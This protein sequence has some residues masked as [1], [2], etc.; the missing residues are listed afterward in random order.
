MRKTLWKRAGAVLLCV[1]LALPS[2]V[3]YAAEPIV[4]V[5][6]DTTEGLQ[7]ADLLI[8]SAR[9]LNEFAQKVTNGNNYAGQVIKLTNDIA[10]DG[11]T[12]NNFTPIGGESIRQEFAGTFDGCG[13]TISGIDVTNADN[14]GL[15]YA[16][17]TSGIVKNVTVK[18]SYFSGTNAGAIA[19]RNTGMILNCRNVNSEITGKGNIGGIV[20]SNNGTNGKVQ[21][22]T[23]SGNV[24]LDEKALNGS[25]LFG[26]IGGVVGRNT[27]NIYN[28]CNTGVLTVPVYRTIVGSAGVGGV[29]GYCFVDG[30]I[31][32]CYN[33]G[34][35]QGGGS[36]NAGI[37][38]NTYG[39]VAN[40]YSSEESAPV[41]FAVMNGTERNC[42]A[43]PEATMKTATF[44]NQLNSNR[45]VN[46][47]W[48]EWEFRAEAGTPVLVEVVD[49]AKCGITLGGLSFEYNGIEKKPSVK[50]TNGVKAMY[51]NKD[52]TVTYENNV[53]AG[54][55]T[56][57]IEGMGRYASGVEKTFTIT[58][59]N[60][61]KCVIMLGA[62]SYA[63][64]GQ[65]KMPV[66]S[67]KYGS[68]ILVAGTDYTVSYENNKNVGTAKVVVTGKGNYT[69]N[70]SK[71][72]IITKGTQ[73]LNYTKTFTKAYGAKAFSLKV[74][75]I[76]DGKLTY[77]TSNK[78]VAT[79]NS[80][81]K[82]TL[83]GTGKATIEVK[84]AETKNYKAAKAK[85]KIVVNPKKQTFKSVK[86]VQD[87]TMKVTWKKDTKANGY[88]MQYS[89]DRNFKK[90][91]KTVKVNTNKTTFKTVSNLKSGKRYYVRVRSFKKS[92]KLY[93][94][95]SKVKSV[96][97]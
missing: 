63:Y 18:D 38:G 41:N 92:P 33:A 29:A 20:G 72:F 54:T 6:A 21:S 27:G 89:T 94:A 59:A 65:N 14:A 78:K 58:P 95:W 7:A 44:L 93:G 73:V 82:V 64:D 61:S 69:R 79:V 1:T 88:Q 74:K 8:S 16:I 4:E 3:V 35:I 70:N 25:D 52:Y 76:G 60:M 17:G 36:S 75:R 53:N 87:K 50:A 30:T 13:Y 57:I 97:M 47:E 23:N 26:S 51:Q 5:T 85:I 24:I 32:N 81:G 11:V 37:V 9:E 43:Y 15:F 86:K 90:S 68:M 96:K 83:K 45:G 56:V 84:A 55:A 46:T 49:I 28:C 39:I 80:S 12:I 67:V 77:K 91:V 40:C 10:F 31:Q 34:M 22:C 19:G 71:T 62:S 48:L 66:A 2:S 42:K